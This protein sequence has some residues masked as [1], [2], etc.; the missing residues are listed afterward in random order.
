MFCRNW[1]LSLD[2]Y[3]F[4]DKV[5][6]CQAEMK[7]STHTYIQ[8]LY[9]WSIAR[10]VCWHSQSAYIFALVNKFIVDVC[11]CADVRMW[12]KWK[13]HVYIRVRSLVSPAK[14]Q[15]QLNTIA[16]WTFLL[17]PHTLTF[18]VCRLYCQD[19][20][21]LFGMF[22]IT[23]IPRKKKKKKQIYLLIYWAMAYCLELHRRQKH[24]ALLFRC[25]PFERVF[26]VLILYVC[27]YLI[28][29]FLFRV[30]FSILKIY[31][32][33]Q[34]TLAGTLTTPEICF[35]WVCWC[36]CVCTTRMLTTQ[37]KSMIILFIFFL[38]LLLFFCCSFLLFFFVEVSA[39]SHQTHTHS[40]FIRLLLLFSDARYSLFLYFSSWGGGIIYIVRLYM[41]VCY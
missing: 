38:L 12:I 10:A 36:A 33:P 21:P 29:R 27:L 20:F 9:K 14:Q 11:V 22:C 24:L 26:V 39:F 40:F 19:F 23:V 15:H 25:S 30:L 16:V 17:G 41:C 8:L 6:L 1:K 35:A 34:H 5:V 18:R 2:A 4:A 7:K 32:Q 13:V 28:L 31:T 3:S 37:I